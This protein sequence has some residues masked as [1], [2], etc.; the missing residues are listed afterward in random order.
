MPVSGMFGWTMGNNWNVAWF[1]AVFVLALLGLTGCTSEAPDRQDLTPDANQSADADESLAQLD[2]RLASLTD[3]QGRPLYV[4]PKAEVQ[5]RLQVL[6][7]APAFDRV[8]TPIE[9]TPD[10]DD[11][12]LPP[13]DLEAVGGRS[14]LSKDQSRLLVWIYT[15]P[16]ETELVDYFSGSEPPMADECRD[17]R[18]TTD[19][20][21]QDFTYTGFDAPLIAPDAASA[22]YTV[23]QDG[24]TTHYLTVTAVNGTVAATLTLSTAGPADQSMIDTVYGFAQ[25]AIS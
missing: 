22:Q 18:V 6:A 3:L 15:A 14:N 11:D 25:Q 8:Y 7:T 23:T 21:T 4:V 1:K 16:N 2:N 20:I 13:S 24:T 9:C 5:G 12:A 10:T 19:G 17:I